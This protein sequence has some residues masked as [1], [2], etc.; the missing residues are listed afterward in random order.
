MGGG[1][2]RAG[3]PRSARRDPEAI[4]RGQAASGRTLANK[5]RATPPARLPLGRSR[6]THP[7]WGARTVSGPGPADRSAAPAARRA[8]RDRP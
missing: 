8:P 4:Y 3:R 2:R 6:A 7:S 5:G 1:E